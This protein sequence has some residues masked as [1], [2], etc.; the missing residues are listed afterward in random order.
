MIL[1]KTKKRKNIFLII[2]GLLLLFNQAL[3]Y[4]YRDITTS[5]TTFGHLGGMVGGLI[6]FII[7]FLN[8][9]RG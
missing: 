1:I 6:F 2:F 3:F 8:K 5:G 9:K 7:Y 4:F